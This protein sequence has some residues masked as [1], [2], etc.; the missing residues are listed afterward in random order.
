MWQKGAYNHCV[1]MYMYMYKNIFWVLILRDQ[2]FYFIVRLICE[3]AGGVCGEGVTRLYT[4][5]QVTSPFYFP[6]RKD[7]SHSEPH[8]MKC[9]TDLAVTWKFWHQYFVINSQK[10]FAMFHALWMCYANN[11]SFWKNFSRCFDCNDEGKLKFWGENG[12]TN[13]HILRNL[14]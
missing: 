5:K 6:G 7:F 11:F 8:F 10:Y 3:C 12:E 14:T 13:L 2:P 9:G 1:C 4:W